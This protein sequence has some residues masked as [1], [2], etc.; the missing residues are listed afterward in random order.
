M[1]ALTAWDAEKG[2]ERD[3]ALKDFGQP[4]PPAPRP[5][6]P[7]LGSRGARIDLQLI[8]DHEG[9]AQ[10]N[11]Y[12]TVDQLAERGGLSWCELHAVLHNRPFQKMG[13]NEAM[14]E[15]RALEARYLAALEGGRG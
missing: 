8:K 11:H 7:I 9:Q 15:S 5:T 2:A 3:F 4:A 14:I 13:Q 12:Q 10:Q 6:F 1:A